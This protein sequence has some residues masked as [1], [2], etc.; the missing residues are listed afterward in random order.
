[1]E[2]K[3][4]RYYELKQLQK[5]IDEEVEVLRKEILQTYPEGIND[6]LGAYQVKVTFQER[7]EYDDQALF[8]ALPDSSVWRLLSKADGGK[9]SSLLKLNVISEE[10]LNGTYKIRKVPYIQVA[11]K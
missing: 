11:K 2:E 7:R 9:I 3:L 6:E 10:V 1:M 4:S 8:E 5:E